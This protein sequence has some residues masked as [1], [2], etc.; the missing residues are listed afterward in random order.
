MKKKTVKKIF[1]IVILIMILIII[2]LACGFGIKL[3]IKNKYKKI[4]INNNYGNYEL[5]QIMDGIEIQNVKLRNNVL[6]LEDKENIIWLSREEKESIILNKEMKTAIVS[7]EDDLKISSLN[8]TYIKE[9]FENDDFKFK[10]LG[11]EKNYVLLE[12]S[13]TKTGFINILYLNLDSKIIEKEVIKNNGNENIIEY[14][15][16]L[17]SISEEEVEKPD[18]TEYYIVAQ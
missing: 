12:F 3:F 14:K 9:Y 13:N 10:Y 4:L 15:I 11:K 5:T 18:L 1:R 16:K 2:I 7:S 6:V 8:D 17:N